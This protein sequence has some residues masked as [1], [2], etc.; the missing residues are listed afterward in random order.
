MKKTVVVGG[1]NGIGLAISKVLMEEGYYIII[2]DK[3]EPDSKSFAGYQNYKFIYTNLYYFDE[4]LFRDLANDKNIDILMITAGF[5]RVASFEYLHLAEISSLMQVN[6]IAVFKIISC[7]Y[8]RIKSKTLFY[9]GIMTSIAGLIS[10]PLFTVYAASKAALC[11]FI[12]S[13]NIEIEMAGSKNRILNIAPASI[14]GTK[15]NGGS[16]DIVKIE[17]LAKEIIKKVILQKEIF[18]PRY[19]ETFKSIIERYQKNPH[20][21]GLYSY[22]YKVQSGRVI[23]EKT[24]KI[25]YMSGT[26]DLFHVGHLNL[27]KRAKELCDYLIVGVHSDASHKGKETFIPF[28]ERKMIVSACKYVDKVV[29][30]CKED[31]DAW[32]LWHYD[33]LFVGSDYKGSERFNNY[34]KYFENKNVEI[35]YF[36]YTKGT[37]S[38]QIRKAVEENINAEW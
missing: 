1:S 24:V 21:Y 29:D 32:D 11:K 38:T 19:N 36:P 12:E 25:G 16:N 30:S 35:I 2:V 8:N 22:K 37:S 23:N 14:Q 17:N 6:T 18:I 4:N 34:E 33:I 31:S 15:F 7:F 5:G 28:D 27:I 13:I 9:C 20:E 26:F 3:V 10:S